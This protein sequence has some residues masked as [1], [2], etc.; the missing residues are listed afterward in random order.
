MSEITAAVLN[1]S[2]KPVTLCACGG[3]TFVSFGEER[4]TV[5]RAGT[6]RTFAPGHDARLKGMLIRAAVAGEVIRLAP[7][8][9]V[10][11]EWFAGK[12]GFAH[13]VRDGITRQMAKLQAKVAKKIAADDD[14]RPAL[15][16]V[17]ELEV[18]EAAVAE[19][20]GKP[21]VRKVT[22]KVGRWPYEG[23][24]IGGVFHYKNAAGESKLATKFTEI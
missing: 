2:G 8:D 21:E 1:A 13:M 17:A 10:S 4:T 6:T 22:A 24:V 18:D 12:F 9:V 19:A 5:C 14:N 20:L 16:I 23:T 11:P 3:I 7:G 15:E